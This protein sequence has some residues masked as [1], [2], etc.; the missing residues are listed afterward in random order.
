MEIENIIKRQRRFFETGKTLD[1]GFRMAALR[2]LERAV[3]GME[4]QICR[5]LKE[6]LGKS[7]TEGYMC[8]V[9]L[10]L[11]ELREQRRQLR[12]NSR[13]R[14]VVST[15]ANFPSRG[16][17]VQEPY[18][19]TLVMSP[20]NY[21]F[22]LAI[23]PLAGAIAAGNCC[24]V[25]PSAYAPATSR[26][27]AELLAGIFPERYVAVV[28]GGR[29]ENRALLEQRFDYIF[30]TGSV[31][32]GKL[33]ME[34][35]AA[36]LTPVSLELGGKSPCIVDRTAKLSLAAR[37][38]V[39]G[40]LLNCGQ[41]CVAPD[42]V[43]VERCVAEALVRELA[44]W[45]RRM[46]GEDALANPDYGRIVNRKHFDRIRGLMD[47]GK[48][49][50]GGR[51]REKT[52]QIEPTL[53]YPVSGEDAVMREEIFGPVLP[54]LV[55]D[56]ME[57]ARR[58]VRK[59]PRPLACYVF[60]RSSRTKRM[61]VR[62]TSFGGGCVNDTV[63]HLTV[64]GLPFGG[65]GESGMGAYHGKAGFKTFSHEKSILEKSVRLDITARYQPFTG[66]KRLLI[67]LIG[68]R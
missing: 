18:G 21:P 37:R 57:E 58:F 39:F 20:W 19:V 60:T 15:L 53:L 38:I 22:M 5:A 33:V 24:V 16:Y 30:F 45:I 13:A 68:Q 35:A 40:K 56:S 42:Y 27:I 49:I 10:V 28:E 12:R 51:S 31:S 62:E 44:Y 50:Y 17:L 25:K 47:E 66:W 26:L 64:P 61:F 59:R 48:V 36:H 1:I 8:E 7:E 65:V 9:G 29:E 11:A 2:R 32:V 55:V 46:Y 41:T 43:L 3:R 23:E 34:K 54:V 6:D 67:R 52:L 4:G 14:R 63:M